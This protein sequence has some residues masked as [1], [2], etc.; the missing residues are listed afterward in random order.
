MTQFLI[1]T[2]LF[3]A[4]D[5]RSLDYG[6]NPVPIPKIPETP[7]ILIPNIP[8][9]RYWKFWNLVC[10]SLNDPENFD[11]E[12]MIFV[13]GPILRVLKFDKSEKFW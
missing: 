3:V 10:P 7:K 6:G 13:L 5:S 2:Y 8:K 1:E 4:V 11:P 9:S 12:N